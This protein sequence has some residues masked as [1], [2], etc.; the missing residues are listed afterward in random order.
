MTTEVSEEARTKAIK[1]IGMYFSTTGG[2]AASV[3]VLIGLG[4]RPPGTGSQNT[5]DAY[6]RG[7]VKGWVPKTTEHER[8]MA[9]ERAR[10]SRA[11]KK[12][13]NG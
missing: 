8:E 6:D 9:R 4:W 11:R 5:Q 3:D 1:A 7:R 10:R 13:S 12:T 2:A